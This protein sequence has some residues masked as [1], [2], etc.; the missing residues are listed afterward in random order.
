MTQEELLKRRA[1]LEQEAE[2]AKATLF[3]IQGAVALIEE[4]LAKLGANGEQK[5]TEPT[6]EQ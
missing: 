5:N 1:E 4:M 6:P 2:R 3:R